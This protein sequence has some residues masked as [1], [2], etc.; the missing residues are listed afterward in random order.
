MCRRLLVH[1]EANDLSREVLIQAIQIAKRTGATVRCFYLQTGH[2]G[3]CPARD[4]AGTPEEGRVA[5]RVLGHAT[6]RRAQ[7]AALEAGVPSEGVYSDD[8]SVGALEAIRMAA[9]SWNADLVL[10]ADC[11][12]ASSE[13]HRA[14]RW[15]LPPRPGL[16]LNVLLVHVAGSDA[17]PRIDRPGRAVVRFADFGEF[18]GASSYSC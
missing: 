11:G 2:G 5:A 8:A 4:R 13:P 17:G 1:L 7:S 6:L 3:R 18:E 14:R 15:P 12:L 16:S 9:V 10:M